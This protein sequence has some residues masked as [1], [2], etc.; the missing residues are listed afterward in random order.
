M[1]AFDTSNLLLSFISISMI[2]SVLWVCK[3]N[4]LFNSIIA[5]GIFSL[6]CCISYLIMDAPDVAMTEAALGVCITTII[7]LKV[8]NNFSSTKELEKHNRIL[9]LII[10]SAF[11][12]FLIYAGMDLPE[13]GDASSPVHSYVIDYYHE[14]TY[15]EIGIP[16]FVAAILASYRG[17]DTFGETLVIYIAGI[18]TI[19]LL[20]FLEEEPDEFEENIII[21]TS[22]KIAFPIIAVFVLYIQINGTTS[23]GGGFQAGAILASLYMAMNLGLNYRVDIRHL[24]TYSTFGICIYMIPGIIAILTG[25]EFLNYN[26]LR[27]GS[28]SQKI[29]IEIVEL[30]IALTVSSTIVILYQCFFTTN[31]T[32]IISSSKDS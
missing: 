11:A 17:Y 3:T 26:A 8:S 10:S 9:A 15:S 24:V 18:C 29:G 22:S 27:L 21:S 2:L 5:L 12:A 31:V 19:F 4:K 14:N 23:P 6:L 20:S 16:S 32:K 1:M 28:M 30:G 25:Y 7:M 13:F